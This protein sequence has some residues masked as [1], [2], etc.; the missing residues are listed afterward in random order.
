MHFLLYPFLLFFFLTCVLFQIGNVREENPGSR[1]QL[2]V[3]FRKAVFPLL[4]GR[5]F[6]RCYWDRGKQGSIMM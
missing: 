1:W 6:F 4:V 5:I 3:G 2:H